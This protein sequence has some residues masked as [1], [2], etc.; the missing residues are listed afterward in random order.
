[1]K[2]TTTL[3]RLKDCRNPY[4]CEKVVNKL[5][6]FLGDA[7]DPDAEINLLTILELNG[8]RDMLWCLRATNEDSKRI[9]AELAIK[10]TEQAL[11][12]FEEII[13][14]ALWKTLRRTHD[15]MDE[16]IPRMT[17]QGARDYMD[18]KIGLTELFKLYH[19][20]VAAGRFAFDAADRITSE[21]TRMCVIYAVHACAA[22]N[23]V[24]AAAHAAGW[25]KVRDSRVYPTDAYDMAYES[26]A[27][28]YD[29]ASASTRIK[30][31]EIIRGL[32]GEEK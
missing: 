19:R 31:V 7:F 26:A 17:V 23:A 9:S 1:M 11:S 13:D 27:D 2:L 8:V 4:G 14:N 16:N 12:P 24:Y 21:I 10:C 18:G 6:E 29:Y 15:F 32:L 22:A 28:V 5:H 30:Q 25:D 3:N 20:A